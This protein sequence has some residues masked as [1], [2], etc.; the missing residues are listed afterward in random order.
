MNA[1]RGALTVWVGDVGRSREPRCIQ[2]QFLQHGRQ[3][4][5]GHIADQE[6]ACAA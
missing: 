5:I 3:G 1:I 6:R 4:C 2:R